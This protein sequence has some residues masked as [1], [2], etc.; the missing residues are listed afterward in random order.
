MPKTNQT[1]QDSQLVDSIS[2]YQRFGPRELLRHIAI[3]ALAKSK[4][5]VRGFEEDLLRPRVHF[6]CLH[7]VFS[8]EARGFES[9]VGFL[10]K[11]HRFISYSDAVQRVWQGPIDQPYMTFSFDDG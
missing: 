8:D 7:S 2:S 6:V 9:L 4:K 1:G 11:T 5:T 10:S 3:S